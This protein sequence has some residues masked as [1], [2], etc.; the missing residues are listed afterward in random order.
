MPQKRGLLEKSLADLAR[1][2]SEVIESK[3]MDK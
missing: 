1:E 3:M 2:K